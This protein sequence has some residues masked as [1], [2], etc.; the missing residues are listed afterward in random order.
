MTFFR[1][2]N[3]DIID[4]DVVAHPS[5]TVQLN[6]DQVT[7]SIFLDKPF[8][9]NEM[10]T[11]V[12]SGLSA[13]EG[14]TI[15]KQGPFTASIDIV[16]VEKGATNKELYE[17]ILALY[18]FYAL[19]NA[20]YTPDVTGSETT[21]FRV[22]TIPEIY[23]DRQIHTGSLSASDNDSAGD[24]RLLFDNGMG[25]IYSGSLSGNLVGNIFYSEGLVV[26]KAGGLQDADETNDFGEDSPN[27]FKW[28]VSFEGNHTIPTKIFRCRAPAG[29][30]NASTNETY[31]TVPTLS[32]SQFR[33]EKN[34]ILTGSE[35][36]I[37]KIG[38]YNDRYE[39]CAIANLAQPI[40][41]DEAQDILFR[42]RLD[43]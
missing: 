41:K 7:G 10:E 24:E 12:W 43:F 27:N 29:Q 30:L 26:L 5:Y 19:L 17:S 9:N 32:S 36:Y 11:R 42:I 8:L 23:Y 6:G 16:D 38:L 18:D 20:D 28:N 22:I 15:E 40:R 1:F 34:R 4:T 33:N 25:G 2:E 39:L 13:R 21:R 35:T 3:E 31:F 37:T 14:G